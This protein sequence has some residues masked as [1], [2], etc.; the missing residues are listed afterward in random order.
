MATITLET[1]T[2]T[3]ER[4]T[5]HN[6]ETGFCVLKIKAKN[7]Q[8]LIAVTGS[9]VTVTA[10]EYVEC[11]GIWFNDKTYGL[12]FKAE[13]LNFM[14][15]DTLDG[16]EKYLGSGLIKGIGPG[17]AKR[18]VKT[19][20]L[21]VFDIIEHS[22]YRLIEVEGLGESRREKIIL[23]WE[24]QKKVR[25]IVMFLHSYGVGTARAVRIYK[26]YGE[27]AINKIKANPYCL[28][29][30][31]RGIGFKTADLLAI[32]L[33][34]APDS[35]IRAKA[36]VKH[37]LQEQSG[38]GHCAALVDT[39]VTDTA[40]LLA[41]EPGLITQAIEAEIATGELIVDNFAA[42]V[43]VF[44]VGFYRAEVAV[45]NK[46]K[47]LASYSPTWGQIDCEKAIAWVEEKVKIK[48]SASQTT[49]VKFAITNKIVVITGGPG[50][51]KTTVVNSILKIIASKTKKILLCAPTGRAAKR[52]TESTGMEAKTLHRLLETK[53]EEYGFR[54][55]EHN[56]LDC[57]LLVVDEISMVDILMMNHL[58]KALPKTSGLILVGDVDQ[59]PSVGPGAVLANIID[60][61]VVPTIKLTEI[62]RQAATSQIIVNAHRINQG[63]FPKLDY[64]AADKT[65]FY[66][67]KAE[68]PLLIQQKLLQVVVHKLQ[69]VFNLNPLTEVQ[70]LTPM[71]KGGLGA[72]SL[73]IELQKQLNTTQGNQI[74]RFGTTFSV[75]DK[76][77][78]TVNNYDK[79]VFNGD[80]GFIKQIDVDESE[81]VINF[82]GRM[83]T[84][85]LD[86]LDEIALAYAI[87]IHKSQGSEYPA[88]VIPLTT[89]HF[90]LLER[91]LLY[92][93]VTRGKN[94]VIVI[95]QVKALGIA[96]NNKR[97]SLR[98]TKLAE[99]LQS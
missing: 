67:I 37:I 29:N 50:V 66:F 51:G 82:E 96:I 18:L 5:F 71:N 62:F 58:L 38:N 31:I 19:F 97:A 90:P 88:I 40:T 85:D 52:L 11:K 44:L 87:T 12:Q 84:Y 53:A 74:S 15:P 4:I 63:N 1:L 69:P 24:E 20:G 27:Q 36:G 55:N 47:T 6:A 9:A 60:S 64:S 83:V 95:G 17:F 10:G 91:N 2:G 99:R 25:E 68:D 81:V 45:A 43:G 86:E 78:Q 59:L 3:I 65:D 13:M 61:A 79:D 21:G 57:E 98:L 93:G 94:L 22:P 34:I 77:I 32:K 92:T 54:Y 76:I 70:V 8:E 23:A 41:V 35:L 14:R 42:G 73:N 49:A 89:Q 28:A 26:T 72:R 56:Q 48:L 30:D 33:G 16:I 39:L 75:G 80:I 7:R 46:L